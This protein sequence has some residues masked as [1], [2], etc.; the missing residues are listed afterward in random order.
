MTNWQTSKYASLIAFQN[1][2]AKNNLLR[3]AAVNIPMSD[4]FNNTTTQNKGKAPMQMPSFK[5][6]RNSIVYNK[7]DSQ[8]GFGNSGSKGASCSKVSWGHPKDGKA[9]FKSPLKSHI[10][11]KRRSS[12]LLALSRSLRITTRRIRPRASSLPTNTTNVAGQLIALIVVR[13]ATNFLN[14]LSQ[15]HDCLRVLYTR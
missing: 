14:V 1:D 9:G 12:S 10:S 4:N 7:H 5:R 2:A 11:D 13:S 6:P 8:G 3:S 15:S